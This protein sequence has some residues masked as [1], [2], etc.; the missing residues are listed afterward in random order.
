MRRGKEGKEDRTF[1]GELLKRDL[2][3]EGDEWRKGATDR[4]NWRLLVEREK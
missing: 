1:D 4:M 2:E 3:I